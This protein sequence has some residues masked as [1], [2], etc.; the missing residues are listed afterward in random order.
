[1]TLPKNTALE[2]CMGKK[3]VECSNVSEPH[4]AQL[5]TCPCELTRIPGIGRGANPSVVSNLA[6]VNL[7]TISKSRG[8][9]GIHARW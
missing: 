3:V 2:Y 8:Q 1:M 5:G 7:P 4:P 9:K 6:R